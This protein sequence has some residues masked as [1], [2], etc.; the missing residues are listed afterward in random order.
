MKKNDQ[1][2]CSKK[3]LLIKVRKMGKYMKILAILASGV[4]FIS[5]SY[6]GEPYPTKPITLIVP[7]NPGE[8]TDV[9]TRALC[10][11]AAKKLGQ[12][13]IILNKPG[14]GTSIGLVALKGEKPDGYSLG[15]LTGSGI[16]MQYLQKVPYDVNRDFTPII[17][18]IE[19]STMGIVVK[20]DS[21]WG[22]MRDLIDYTKNNPGKIKY[23]TSIGSP[24]HIVMETMKKNYGVNWTLVP[25]P[26]PSAAITSL[27]GGHIDCVASSSQWKPQVSSGQ[28]RLLCTYGK[29]RSVSFPSTPTLMDLG[30]N[31]YGFSFGG[32]VGPKGLS[33]SI[34]NKL[35]EVFKEAMNDPQFIK[36][37]EKFDI[38]PS[39]NDPLGLAKDIKE[40]HELYGKFVA[41][42]GLVKKE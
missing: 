19:F 33:Q 30:Y 13:I 16:M 31:V 20:S 28:F 35:H 11:V 24:H 12:P 7:W 18:Y 27:L 41:E 1:R 14:G 22:T 9:I 40:L 21:P 32:I 10:E 6:A 23:G 3:G 37:C 39:Y 8:A 38:D 17:R 26:S 25:F 5:L 42:T 2:K 34:V 4:T 29:K 15:Y 36:T